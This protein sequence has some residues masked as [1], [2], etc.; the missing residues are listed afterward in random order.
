MS[1]LSKF[2]YIADKVTG[3]WTTRQYINKKIKEYGDVLNL[4]INAKNKSIKA[5]VLLKG[6]K[7]PISINVNKYKL[8]NNANSAT[9]KILDANSNKAWVNAII[10]N[11]VYGKEFPMPAKAMDFIDDFLD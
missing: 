9:I 6:E 10:K 5:S 11:F 4:Q 3:S 2:A 7:V 1:I 8:E